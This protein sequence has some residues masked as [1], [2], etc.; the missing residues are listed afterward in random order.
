MKKFL[1]STTAL[2]A[3]LATAISSQ[4]QG[5]VDFANNGSTRV[6]LYT[7][8]SSDPIYGPSGYRFGLYMGPLG[9]TESQLVLIAT[10][11]NAPA[12][13]STSPLAGLFNGG[14]YYALPAQYAP[15]T[16]YAFQIRGW[17]YS[18][19]TSYE[20]ALSS[21]DP[22]VVTG[23]S[24]M[25]YVALLAVPNPAPPLFGTDAGQVG[26]FVLGAIPEPATLAIGG[27]GAAGLLFFRRRK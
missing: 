19:G 23:E 26:G 7:G 20:Q 5:Y 15:G 8:G 12:T 6:Y 25:G 11:V 21:A 24:A 1:L 10:T 3:L 9:S 16:T 4:A 18:G 27:L 22:N 13:N 2:V 17:T 14:S